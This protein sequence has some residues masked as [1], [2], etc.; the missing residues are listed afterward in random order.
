M[1]VHD[2]L[3]KAQELQA[4]RQTALQ[5]LAEIL[6]ERKQLESMLA[7]T[8]V[9]YGKA[10]AAA[11]KAGWSAAELT[12]LGAPEPTRRPSARQR[13]GGINIAAGTGTGAPAE[14]PPQSAQAPVP[15]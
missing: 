15:A 10:Y 4:A 11:E 7:D 8:E 6:A 5:P 9:G 12:A 13:R 3:K 2:I 1:D 14:I